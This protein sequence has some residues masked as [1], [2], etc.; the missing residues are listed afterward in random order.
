M[1]IKMFSSNI[2]SVTVLLKNV[3]SSAIN[4]TF[5]LCRRVVS[6]SFWRDTSYGNRCVSIGKRKTP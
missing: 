3:V 4:I 2:F 6:L 1:W 5:I